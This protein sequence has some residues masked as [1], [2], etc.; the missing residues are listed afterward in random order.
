MC[1]KPCASMGIYFGAP[2]WAPNGYDEDKAYV[3]LYFKTDINVRRSQLAY[4]SI[5]LF[6]ELGG[7]VGLLLG[8]SLMDITNLM[9]RIMLYLKRKA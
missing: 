2:I 3:K 7:Y 5:S 6:G 9:E 4:T 1:K 8:I